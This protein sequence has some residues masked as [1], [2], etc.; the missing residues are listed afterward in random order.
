MNTKQLSKS[1]ST[2]FNHVLFN[3]SK[4]N[5]NYYNKDLAFFYIDKDTNKNHDYFISGKYPIVD[6]VGNYSENKVN[7]L[8]KDIMSII[9]P[10]DVIVYKKDITG[11]V[12]VYVG[13][14]E[15]IE[16]FY[17][18][19]ATGNYDFKIKKDK[20][21]NQV[22]LN[23]KNMDETKNSGTI[24]TSHFVKIA[25]ENKDKSILGDNYCHFS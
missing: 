9:E 2:L 1:Y 4:T 6:S 7:S 19:S 21:E 8:I 23:S 3:I 11:D 15:V 20:L 10:G 16:S 18:N 22:S 17:S 24:H 14:N 25:G 13:D 12:V 5:S